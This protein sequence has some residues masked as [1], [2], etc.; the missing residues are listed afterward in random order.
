M[1][2]KTHFIIISVATETLT[3]HSLENCKNEYHDEKL[4]NTESKIYNQWLTTSKK[5]LRG[6]R[7]GLVTNTI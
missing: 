2:F 1:V 4:C 7:F 6:E 3:L 5:S